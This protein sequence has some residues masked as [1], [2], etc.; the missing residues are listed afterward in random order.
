MR[1]I[2]LAALSTA[3][4]ALGL[5]ALAQPGVPGAHF[6]DN[7][8][9]DG[10]GAV[11]PAEALAKRGDL[12][13]MFDQDASGALEPTEYDL[14]DETRTTD[15][16]LNA[17]GQRFGAMGAVEEG[18]QRGFNDG[19]GDGTVTRAEF[20]DATTPWFAG[21]DTDGNGLIE[22]ADFVRTQ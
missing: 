15:M 8:D 17:A 16:D 13:T 6:I 2:T 12:F 1:K 4:L 19:D 14:F 3:A 11:T 18:L 7:W 22:T 10:D 5:P 21:V 20:E 9:M